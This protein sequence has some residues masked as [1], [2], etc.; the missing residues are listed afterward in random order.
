MKRLLVACEE[1]GVVRRAFAARG[2][3]AYSCDLQMSAD[4]S[5]NHMRCDVRDVLEQ[6]WDMIIAHPECTYIANSGVCWL[7]RDIKRWKQMWDACEFFRLFLDHPCERIAIENPI[8]H[9]YAA[10]WIGTP[11]T[12]TIQPWQFGHGETKRTCLWLKGLPPLVPTQIVDGRHPRT[13]LESPGPNRK[14]N[15]SRTYEGIANA[16]AEQ[17]T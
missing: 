16:M 12:Q 14:R 11:Y 4:G 7:D 10:R 9:K 17:W 15:R 2:W 5:P 6:K 1:S 3:D 13:H 8:P